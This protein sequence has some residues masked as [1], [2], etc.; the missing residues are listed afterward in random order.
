MGASQR[1]R[2]AIFYTM[3]ETENE[4][5]AQG[6]A[7]DFALRRRTHEDDQA[8]NELNWQRKRVGI[9]F[10]LSRFVDR[11]SLIFAWPLD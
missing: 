6:R 10:P 3:K 8:L 1:L 7:V 5:D 9:L 4:L 2:E 11:Q